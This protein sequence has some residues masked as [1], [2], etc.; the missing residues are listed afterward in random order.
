MNQ[1]ES[2]DNIKKYLSRFQAQ[3]Q[4][5]NSNSEYDINIHSENVL[6]PI[7]N[8]LFECSLKNVNYSDG[9]NVESIDLLDDRKKID[10]QITST[11]RLL[12]GILPLPE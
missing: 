5:A 9:K 11:G 7:L 1:K 2:L 10:F 4:I 3:I 6:I 12:F 8:L